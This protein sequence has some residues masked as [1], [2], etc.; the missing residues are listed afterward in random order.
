[1][2]KYATNLA[3]DLSLP[4]I[5]IGLFLLAIAT[6]LP[7]L[8]F[9][10]SATRLR[11]KEMAIGDQIG[12]IVANTLLI[13]GIVAL[14]NPIQA[15]FMQFIISAIFMFVSAFILV[16][17]IK[18]GRKLEKTEGISLILIYVLFIVIEF[19]IK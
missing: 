2:V 18:T 13:L 11:H 6:T 10:I 4:E 3:I 5:T 14:I 16:T 15:D 17:F 19:F 8:I 12:T 1:M 9:G 7:E